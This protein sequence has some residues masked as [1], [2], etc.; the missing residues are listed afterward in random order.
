MH[1]SALRKSLDLYSTQYENF[2][3]L[4]DFNVEVDSSD[5]KDFCKSYN[6]KSLVWVPTCFKNSENPS[7]ID[8]ILTNS[9]YSLQSSC[10]IE[11]GLPDFHKMTVAV[12]KASFQK[13][14]PKIITYRNYELF[15]NELYKEDLVFELSNESFGFSKLK[16]FLEICENTLDRHA[17]HK[18]NSFAGIIL[19]SWIKSFQKQ[20]WKELDWE[21]HFL[22]TKALKAERILT[23]NVTTVYNS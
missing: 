23:N 2:V 11:T 12:M 6:L 14:K 1:L 8:L 22:E 19:L 18:K 21:T 3:V 4:G 5:M 17:P 20:S 9:E 10:V 15:S 7:C 16:R 13:M